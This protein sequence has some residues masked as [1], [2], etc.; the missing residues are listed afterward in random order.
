MKKFLLTVVLFFY[1]LISD[2][3]EADE[4][5]RLIRTEKTNTF[6]QQLSVR[7][8]E[9]KAASDQVYEIPVVVH[10]IHN[11][12][13]ANIP[14]E[15][16]LSQ[17]RV[18][19][20]D[21][22]RKEGTRGFNNHPDGGDPRIEFVMARSSPQ[23]EATNAIVRINRHEKPPPPFG[24]S[25]LAMGAYYSVWDPRDYLNIWAFPG[26]LDTGLGEARFPVSDLPGL[27]N[28]GD[29]IIPGVDSL[30]GIPVGEIDGVAI[31]TLH[32]GETSADSKYNLGRTGTHEIGHFLGLFHI[33]GDEG[34]EGSCETD[35]HCDDTPPTDSRT[36]GCPANRSA[37]DGSSAMIENYM[38][39]TD[40]ACM[41]I[42]TNDQIRRM[43]TVLENSPRRKSL[44][45]SKGLHPP[46]KPTGIPLPED[47]QVKVYPNPVKNK[48][49]LE[50]PEDAEIKGL[51]FYSVSGSLIYSNEIAGYAESPFAVDVPEN[52]YRILVL[53][54][55]TKTEILIKKV[56]AR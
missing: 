34:F 39:Y 10:V 37:C 17:I 36:T 5:C 50:F 52:G 32:F 29:F 41:N 53:K 24:G 40:D 6:E 49:I 31:N 19:N 55:V 12:E 8:A 46:E 44:L 35:D 25:M 43:R 54:I 33:W 15:Q 9:L 45:A 22:R 11:G 14:D 1:S 42:F 18:I 27:E 23:G 38:D 16:I 4:R 13:E 20:E 2:G 51:Y 56:L 26:I 21:F 48:L 30:S 3:Q 7:K 28:E 47:E